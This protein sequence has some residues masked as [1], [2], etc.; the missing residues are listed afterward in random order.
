M[1]QTDSAPLVEV[2]D[3][4][5]LLDGRK[6]LDGVDLS[7]RPGEI[8]TLVG[9]NGS[10]KSTLVRAILGLIE[11]SSGRIW[12]REGLTIGYVP[13]RFAIDPVLPLPVRRFLALTVHVP[14]PALS[15]A[16]AEVRASH[17]L[18]A[19]VHE[20]SGG[21][22]QR[23]LLARAILREPDLLVL[24]EPVQQVDIMGQVEL[25]D[26]IGELRERHGCGILMVSHDLHLVMAGTDRVVCL[27]HHICCEGS[28]Q[29][30]SRDPAYL[31]LFGPEAARA[32]AFYSHDHDHRHG[33][34]GQTL[35]PADGED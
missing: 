30:V 13:Q 32:L 10:G 16:L 22:L 4:S 1:G 8:L 14:E 12:R 6:V 18:E 29:T 25:F 35:T 20:L 27:H 33:L 5:V 31:A 11:P 15:E 23:V 9:P 34:S 26:L 21:E 28:P 24:D 17:L 3:L 19:Q 2:K 7:V